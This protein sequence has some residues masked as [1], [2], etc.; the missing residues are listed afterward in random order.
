[1]STFTPVSSGWSRKR[2]WMTMLTYRVSMD[3]LFR[4][5]EMNEG[6]GGPVGFRLCSEGD[7]RR[8]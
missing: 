4:G 3:G 2:L 5:Y 6:I 8:R 7:R 1:M